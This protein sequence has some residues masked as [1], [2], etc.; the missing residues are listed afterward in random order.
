MARIS[1]GSTLMG[2]KEQPPILMSLPSSNSSLLI[3][4]DSR[5]INR[6]TQLKIQE[7]EMATQIICGSVTLAQP[8]FTKLVE[9]PL[10]PRADTHFAI[11]H[12]TRQF[13]LFIHP[14]TR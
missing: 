5:T 4:R 12:K 6:H 13:S 3:T 2:T 14:S 10:F 1:Y 11:V 7:V 9:R 8:R